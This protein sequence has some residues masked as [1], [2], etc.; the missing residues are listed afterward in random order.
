MPF[1]HRRCVAIALL[2]T[3]AIPTHSLRGDEGL[4]RAIGDALTHQMDALS[5][6]T[7]K[8]ESRRS[9]DMPIEVL[10]KRIGLPSYE[11]GFLAPTETTYRW[12]RGNAY[13]RH[14]RQQP[15]FD[16]ETGEPLLGKTLINVTDEDTYLIKSQVFYSASPDPSGKAPLLVINPL[17]T[18]VR[19]APT[20]IVM[21]AYYL[22]AAGFQMPR[23]PA[24]F[25]RPTNHV[26][27]DLLQSDARINSVKQ[28]T[29]GEKT[30]VTIE[31]ELGERTYNFSLD[32][33]I[34]YA[35][36][37]WEEFV[38][39]R[40]TKACISSDF[41]QIDSRGLWLP[42]RITVRHHNYFREP[43]K[44]HDVALF[45][46]AFLVTSFDASPIPES[47]FVLDYSDPGA[48]VSDGTLPTAKSRKSGRIDYQIPA[49][50]EDLDRVVEEAIRGKKAAGRHFYWLVG[51]TVLFGLVIALWILQR[52]RRP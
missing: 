39:E 29:S 49:D 21:Q 42:K 26:L 27:I 36:V 16:L 7:I 2:V 11:L 28:E 4:P 41:S 20:A 47:A 50:P 30:L 38:N 52:F 45:T 10:L 46:D 43:D 17:S 44:F 48:Y 15:Q 18:L 24:E 22:R 34:N 13:E 14:T 40:L 12:N 23:F 5:P 6:L 9:S 37:S 33:T 19:N 51:T 1:I 31:V 8:W 35:V 25:G 3:I 32:P